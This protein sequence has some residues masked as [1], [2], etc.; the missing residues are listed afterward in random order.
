MPYLS[1]ISTKLYSKSGQIEG[2]DVTFQMHIIAK[3]YVREQGTEISQNYLFF[4][5]NDC[6]EVPFYENVRKKSVLIFITEKTEENFF[7]LSET[8]KRCIF[9]IKALRNFPRT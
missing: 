9:E 2:L 8:S 7:V 4:S 6:V 5:Q 1:L 3:I